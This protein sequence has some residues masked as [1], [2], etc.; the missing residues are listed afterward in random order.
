MMQG[1]N[2]KKMEIRTALQ[3]FHMRQNKKKRR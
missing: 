2:I 3:I 1:C